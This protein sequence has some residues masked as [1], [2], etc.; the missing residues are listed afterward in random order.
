MI[1]VAGAT[2]VGLRNPNSK[3]DAIAIFREALLPVRP[4][5]TPVIQLGE[6]DCGFVIWYRATKYAEPVEDQLE[7][8]IAAYFEFVDLLRAAGYPSVLITG[9]VPPTIRDDQYWGD[10]ANARREIT[11]SLAERTHLT[12]RYNGRLRDEAAKR[13]L[14]YVDVMDS[15]LN[16]E[17]GLLDDRW[18]HPD[19]TDHHLDPEQA[20]A[21]WADRLN[22]L[23]I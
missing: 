8:A 7:Q 17:T 13:A 20:G 5:S 19:P 21:L 14:P 23:Q 9:A 4:G 22:S 11:A 6:V 3:T 16:A 15:V 12:L 10:V 1:A 2:A 18:R